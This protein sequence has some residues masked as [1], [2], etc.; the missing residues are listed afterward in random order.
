[1]IKGRNKEWKKT[2]NLHYDRDSVHDQILV[3]LPSSLFLTRPQPVLA[4]STQPRLSKNSAES[5]YQESPY[6]CYL[7][8][9]W[10]LIK[11][12]IPHLWCLSP[13][14]SWAR[15]SLALMSLLSNFASTDPLHVAGWL[16]SHWF[17][18][19]SELSSL[20]PQL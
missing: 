6:P 12:L 19:N 4:R 2:S 5:V 1:M 16:N 15:I 14:P 18:L 3:W 13:W 7:I 11:F 17:L 9:P 8:N 20:S 10:Y